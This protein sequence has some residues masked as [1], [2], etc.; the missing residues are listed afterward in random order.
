MNDSANP[1]TRAAA[2]VVQGYA[3]A[4]GGIELTPDRLGELARVTQLLVSAVAARAPAIAFGDDPHAYAGT[5]AELRNRIA[6]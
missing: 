5:L 2:E 4:F 6:S 3:A 1:P